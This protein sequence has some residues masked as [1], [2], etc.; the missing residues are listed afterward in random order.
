MKVLESAWNEW[1][2]TRILHPVSQSLPLPLALSVSSLSSSFISS[3]LLPH[4]EPLMP[5]L[6]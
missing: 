2:P 6:P 1:G 3:G 5:Y 4:G